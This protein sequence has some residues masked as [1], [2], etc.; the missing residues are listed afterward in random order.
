[1]SRLTWADLASPQ[2]AKRDGEAPKHLGVGWSARLKR[3]ADLWSF[4]IL[5]AVPGRGEIAIRELKI[6]KV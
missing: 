5:Y 3:R 2:G 1:M 4:Y 6:G